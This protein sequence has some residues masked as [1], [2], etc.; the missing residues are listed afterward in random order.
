MLS[1]AQDKHSLGP[2][3]RSTAQRGIPVGPRGSQLLV[4]LRLPTRRTHN[5]CL[6]IIQAWVC[7]D[8]DGRIA[9]LSVHVLEPRA[10]GR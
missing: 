9:D 7:A 10:V 2:A 8:G 3:S 1:L 5:A 4:K 6:L